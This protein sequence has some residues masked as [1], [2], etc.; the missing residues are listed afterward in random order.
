MRRIT[1]IRQFF[2]ASTMFFAGCGNDSTGSID[3]SGTLE[4]V[5]VNIAA[6]TSGQL[7]KLA[8][9]EGDVVT[10]GDTIAMIDHALLELQLQQASAGVDLAAAQYTLLRNGARKED[11][12][13]AE[14]TV[15]QLQSSHSSAAID[16]ERIKE[17]YAAGAVSKKQFDDAESRFTITAA[18]YSA[19]QQNLEKLRHFARPEEIAA[20]KARVDQA[21]AQANLIRKQISDS[22][23]IAPVNGTVTYKPV[24]AGE[25]IN[26]GT[27]IVRLSQLERMELMIYV[28]ETELGKV[29]L[30]AAADVTIDTFPEKIYSATVVYVSPV[31][32]F[33][34][35]N[36]QTKDE[37][38]KLVF[39]VK[40]EVDNSNG[41]L[42][43]G[44][45][46]DAVV[47]QGS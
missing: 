35:R 28:N 45:P 40:L 19:A 1:I 3:A 12:R 20:A 30:G 13:Y 31:A 4:A 11:I 16:F 36:V 7:L 41:E 46:A 23:I 25:L 43:S 14:E 37:R 15:R 33:T 38:T 6:R 44:M 29:K 39:G 21:S 22:Y 27:V 32:E 8:V 2:I 24:E 5:E 10:T 18:Q 26:P 34:P 17:L 9:R 47:R 42:K